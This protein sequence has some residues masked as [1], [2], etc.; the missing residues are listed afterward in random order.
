LPYARAMSDSAQAPHKSNGHQVVHLKC[1]RCGHEGRVA[2]ERVE[3]AANTGKRL[4]CR[5][6]RGYAFQMRIIWY[7][8]QPPNNVVSIKKR[9]PRGG[10]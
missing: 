7:G 5:R 9:P 1:L 4:S 6:C 10:I 3:L 2:P 8:G